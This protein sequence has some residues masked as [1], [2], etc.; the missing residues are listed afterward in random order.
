[1][2]EFI[3]YSFNGEIDNNMTKKNITEYTYVSHLF[4]SIYFATNPFCVQT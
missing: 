4:D 2:M 3:T 1:M